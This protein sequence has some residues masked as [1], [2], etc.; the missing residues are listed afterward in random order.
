MRLVSPALRPLSSAPPRR[1]AATQ[2]RD[3]AR[4]PAPPV[5]EGVCRPPADSAFQ[6]ESGRGVPIRIC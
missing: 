6:V 3:A 1:G 5:R 4:T 2:G